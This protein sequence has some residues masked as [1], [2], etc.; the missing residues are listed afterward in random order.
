MD[1]LSIFAVG[2]V[3]WDHFKDAIA[4]SLGLHGDDRS[5]ADAVRHL[6]EIDGFEVLAIA[7]P[8]YEDDCG[9]AFSTFSHQMVVLDADMNPGRVRR[10]GYKDFVQSLV[11]KLRLAIP[12]ELVVVKNLQSL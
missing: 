10:I 8:N 1:E 2:E 7:N 11:T 9:I 4:R 12:N 6:W 3:S 5:E